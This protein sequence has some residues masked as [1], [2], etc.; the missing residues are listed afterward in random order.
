MLTSCV[1]NYGTSQS[2]LCDKLSVPHIRRFTP[3][4]AAPLVA[5]ALL[6]LA[7]QILAGQGLRGRVVDEAGL[8]P[9][10]QAQL[11]VASVDGRWRG[12]TATD[13]AGLFRVEVPRAA[14]YRLTVTHVAFR[15]YTSDTLRIGTGEMLNVEVR[16]G[17]TTIPLQPLVITG[18]R[19]PRLA[20]FDERRLGSTFGRFITREE[21]N[22]RGTNRTTELLR[23]VPGVH[24][25]R[26]AQ[27]GGM[28]ASGNLIGMR[29]GLG[30]C[31]P[32]IFIDGV[33]VRQY[34]EN[35]VDDM[36]SP[37]QIEG[38][39]VYTS[40]VAAPARYNEGTGCGVVLFWTRTGHGDEGRPWNWKRLA[41]AAGALTLI[42]ILVR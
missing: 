5:A 3:E 16:L 26:G 41:A 39:E 15:P 22:A 36:L 25:Q 14:L 24:L 2:A 4:G 42:F 7:P 37:G 28:A 8:A 1:Y 27:R 38:V 32:S 31:S 35:T 29:G 19:D 40:A 34:A 6:V 30:L 12:S 11:E 9:V 10:A 21:I 23:M 20:E 18:R 17:Q 33:A 13:T